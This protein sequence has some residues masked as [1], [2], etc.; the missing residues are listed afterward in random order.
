MSSSLKKVRV[1]ICTY[2]NDEALFKNLDSL[3]AS[4]LL[5]YDYQVSILNNFGRMSLPEKYIPYKIN[6]INNEA[7]P[8]FSRGHLSRSWNQAIMLGFKDLKK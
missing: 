2:N 3:I 5:K 8:D 4:D 7:R 1:F 6:V